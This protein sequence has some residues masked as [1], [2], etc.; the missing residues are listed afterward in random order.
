VSA[1][2]SNDHAKL[3]KHTDV[4]IFCS[5]LFTRFSTWTWPDLDQKKRGHVHFRSVGNPSTPDLDQAMSTFHPSLSRQNV[6]IRHLPTSVSFANHVQP[7]IYPS[8]RHR[9]VKIP[10][11]RPQMTASG[12][13][14][15]RAPPT[16]SWPPRVSV[17]F[18]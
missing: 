5:P 18:P 3:A 1:S 9:H 10:Y 14:T 8:Y 12:A 4:G 15:F 7:F 11:I 17:T 16:R 13:S 6:D 2:V